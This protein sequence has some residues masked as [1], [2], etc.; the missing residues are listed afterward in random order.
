LL[1]VLGVNDVRQSEI[2]TAETLL[3]E[4]ASFALEMDIEGDEKMYTT[5]Y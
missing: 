5:R 1:N 2:H 3:P 4:P